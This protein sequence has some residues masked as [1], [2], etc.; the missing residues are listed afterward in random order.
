MAK[1]FA[2][3]ADGLEEVECLAVVDVLRRS[4]VEVQVCTCT[5]TL[6]I[7]STPEEVDVRTELSACLMLPR[8]SPNARKSCGKPT[9]HF[10]PVRVVVKISY[11][12]CSMSIISLPP[13]CLCGVQSPDVLRCGRDYRSVMD[14]GMAAQTGLSSPHDNPN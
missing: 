5:A 3:L 7:R 2:F 1:V 13:G 6:E 9:D 14:T 8:P 4:G 12:V 10:I 11:T